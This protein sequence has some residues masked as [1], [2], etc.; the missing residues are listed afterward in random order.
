MRLMTIITHSETKLYYT[1][2]HL[3]SHFLSTVTYLHEN[4]MR[5]R[6]A[7]LSTYICGTHHENLHGTMD[8][9]SLPGAT[10]LD[11]SLTYTMHGEADTSHA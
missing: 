2:G 1:E 5:P 10:Y 8:V 4:Y 3:K 11:K 7:F 9:R 6:N